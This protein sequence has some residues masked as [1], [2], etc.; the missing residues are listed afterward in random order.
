MNVV[1]IV[2]GDGEIDAVPLL[3]RRLIGAAGISGLAVDSPIRVPR[4]KIVQEAGL[5]RYVQVA[6]RRPLCAAILV[7]FDGDDDCPKDL[8]PKLEAWAREEAGDRPCAV[9]MA[10][11]EYEAWFLATIESLRGKRGIRVDAEPH[12]RPEDPRDAKGQL[13]LRMVKGRGYVERADQPA[14]TEAFHMPTAYAQCRSFR[15]MTGAFGGLVRGMGID[16]GAWPPP[17]W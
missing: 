5:R 13:R 7:L 17:S 11:R 9:V 16:F 4:G 14:L 12:P 15:R 6:K 3:I 1:P 2:E 10:H 8:A